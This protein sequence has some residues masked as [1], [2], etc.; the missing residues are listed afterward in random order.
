MSLTQDPIFPHLVGIVNVTPD[1]FS[2]GGRYLDPSSAIRKADSLIQEGASI[3]DIGAE[4]SGPKSAPISVEEEWKRLEPVLR[5]LCS[6]INVSVDTYKAETAR[7]ALD[8]GAKYI[9][10]I[11]ALRADSKMVEVVANSRCQVILMHSKEAGDRPHVS[12]KRGSYQNIIS[13]ISDFL[14][15]RAQYAQS[16]GIKREQIILDPGLG[17]FLDKDAT[18]SWEVLKQIEQFKNLEFPLFVGVSRKGFLKT[19]DESSA[20]DRDPI[21]AL[22]AVHLAQSGVGYIRTHNVK[23]TKRFLETWQE[24]QS[25]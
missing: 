17:L 18:F 19:P 16:C 1:S 4:S 11:S 25:K 13:D 2:D 8:C 24:L 10:D 20:S 15:E 6:R 5:E 21:S 9:N 23:M 12:E 14:S 3:I 7:R 22:L